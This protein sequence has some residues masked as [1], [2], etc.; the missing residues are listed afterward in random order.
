MKLYS[1]N[2]IKKGIDLFKK[3]NLLTPPHLYIPCGTS[4]TTTLR[5]QASR[6]LSVA[7]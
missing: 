7:T 4:L 6:S 5:L 3:S 2:K 1:I